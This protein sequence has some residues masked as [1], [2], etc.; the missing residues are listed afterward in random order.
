VRNRYLK[1][2][3]QQA[4]KASQTPKATENLPQW[5]QVE[6]TLKTEDEKKFDAN[7]DGRFQPA[8]TKVYLRRS[9]Q[10]IQDNAGA[11]MAG[12]DVRDSDVLKEY[13]TNK[14]GIISKSES[15]KMKKDAF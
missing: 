4:Q 15:E 14:N 9:Y 12:K 10:E 5:M 11:N 2:Q 3:E 7:R 13:D 1:E 6:P 8:E